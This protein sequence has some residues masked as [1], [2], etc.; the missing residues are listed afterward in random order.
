MAVLDRNGETTS[1]GGARCESGSRRV[2]PAIAGADMIDAREKTISYQTARAITRWNKRTR[3][4]I[5]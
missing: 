4:L 1:S 3:D 5:A 2:H